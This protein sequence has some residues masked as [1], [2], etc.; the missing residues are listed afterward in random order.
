MLVHKVSASLGFEDIGLPNSLDHSHAS[1][2][3]SL[4]SPSLKY[5]INMPIDNPMI[6]YA[7]VDLAYKDNVFVI[8]GGSVYDYVSLGCFRGIQSLH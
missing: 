5:Y 6:F 2:L 3:C 4:P 7:N 1:H 8:F